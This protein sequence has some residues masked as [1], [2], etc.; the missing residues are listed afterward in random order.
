MMVD[1][2]VY[3]VALEKLKLALPKIKSNEDIKKIVESKDVVFNR[4][5]PVFSPENIQK[6]SEEDFKSFLLFENNLH[7]TGF[8]RQGNK[9]CADMEKLRQD[10]IYLL[11]EKNLLMIE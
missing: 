10:L 9:S 11:D 4:F 7:W 1:E 8:H 5:R 2:R 3:Q 6:L